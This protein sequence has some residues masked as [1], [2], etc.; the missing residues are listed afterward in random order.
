M[1]EMINEQNQAKIGRIEDIQVVECKNIAEVQMTEI[2]QEKEVQTMFELERDV[3][4]E[5]VDRTFRVETELKRFLAT[6]SAEQL[7][8]TEVMVDD[9]TFVV[10]YPVA[11][12]V[13]VRRSGFH[14]D[15]D[16]PRPSPLSVNCPELVGV[17]ADQSHPSATPTEAQRAAGLA[18]LLASVR[19]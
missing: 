4:V 5:Y 9:D 8:E 16:T 19:L 1:T 2:A 7:A 11:V 15:T 13:E 3:L 17:Y 10:F 6:L 12:S 14:F 18:V